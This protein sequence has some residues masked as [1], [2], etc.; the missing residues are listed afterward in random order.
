MSRTDRRVAGLS[1]ADLL[2]AVVASSDDAIISKTA[3]G[4]VTSWNA[5]AERIFGYGAEE[6]IGRPIAILAVP[7]QEDEMPSILRRL[8]LGER[9]EHFETTRRHKDGSTILVSLSVSPVFDQDGRLIGASKIARDITAA[10]R[11]A[12]DLQ[13]AEERVRRQQQELL[14]AGRL[15]E[16]GQMSATLAHEIN[17][18]LA[19]ISLHLGA[20][21]RWLAVDGASARPMIEAGVSKAAGQATRAAEIVRRLRA[22]TRPAEGIQSEQPILDILEDAAAIAA[23]DEEFRGVCVVLDPSPDGGLV[24]ADRIEI[25][26]V[27]LNLIRNASQAMEGRERRRLRLSTQSR[28]EMVEVAVADTGCGLTSE[29]RAHLFESFFTTKPQGVGIGLSICRSIIE[30]HG[31]RLWADDNADGGATFRFT[32][33]AA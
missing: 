17:Q 1:D 23:L 25:E 11:L 26:Q 12:E 24:K 27:V 2:A 22:F 8:A 9:V 5:A 32:L 31:G 6:M 16:L 18:P 28:D 19:A 21:R 15:A 20:V 14:H 13:R 4:I 3:D 30:N 33:K 10:R 29:V 7:G